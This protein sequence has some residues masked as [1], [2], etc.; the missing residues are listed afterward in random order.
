[1]IKKNL[2]VYI[3]IPFCEAK[4]AY[5]D[6]LSAPASEE[7]R[8]EY[9]RALQK[10]IQA[11][12]YLQEEYQVRTIFI[13]GGTPSSID[14]M[15]IKSILDEVR[16]IF[17]IERIEG[18]R[19]QSSYI[20]TTIEANPG[21]LTRDKLLVYKK[22][23]INRISM[24]LQST[25]NKELKLLGR[26]HTYEQFEENYILARECGFKDINIDLMSALPSQTVASWEHTLRTVINLNPEHISAYSLIVEPDTPFYERYSDG[27]CLPSEEEDRQMY[28]LTKTI[29][30]ESGY[31]RYEISNYAKPGYESRH[32]CTYWERGEYIGFGLG[33]SSCINNERFHNE[34][35]MQ[36]YLGLNF[37]K[38]PGKRENQKLTSKE[39]MEEFLFLG[40]RMMKGI[41][42]DIFEEYFKT[43]FDTI[44]ST[45]LNKLMKDKLIRKEGNILTLTDRGIDISNYVLS[46]FIL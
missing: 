36:T 13:G 38:D 29:L 30:N 23:G 27:V 40:L 19:S 14:P 34:E 17:N 46:E 25:D 6:F 24:G 31:E 41:D 8:K 43:S 2:G 11:F 39:Q 33:A 28:H 18:D 1:M 21:T 12:S 9:I 4:C 22:S 10:Q 20:E 42:I 16:E 44:F 26:I 35:N 15:D 37:A 32:N 5:C 3:H 45:T 7:V